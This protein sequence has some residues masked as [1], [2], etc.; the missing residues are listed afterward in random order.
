MFPLSH[1]SSS[2]VV[3]TLESRNGSPATN[4]SQEERVKALEAEINALQGLVC[5]LIERN[6]H[7]RMCLRMS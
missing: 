6:E 7:L 2:L 4:V 3:Q 1:S 5:H